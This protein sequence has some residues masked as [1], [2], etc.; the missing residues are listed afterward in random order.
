M[1]STYTSGENEAEEDYEQKF[2]KKETAL[3]HIS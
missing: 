3:W 1:A 2:V